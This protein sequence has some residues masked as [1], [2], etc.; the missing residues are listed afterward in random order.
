MSVAQTTL[1]DDKV[2]YSIDTF[3]TLQIGENERSLWTHSQRIGFHYL[4]ARTYLG[5][6]ID[7]VYDQ[8][9]GTG[10]AGSA[11]AGYLFTGRNV[12]HIDRQVRQLG[13]EC[14]RK[15]VA[16]GFDKAQFP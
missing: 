8:Q 13:T 14:C 1:L 16:A 12:D 2:C 9:I 15:V 4:E 10:D 5:R 11:L 6:Q 7:L 3:A